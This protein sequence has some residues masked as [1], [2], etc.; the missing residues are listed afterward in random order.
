MQFL[1]SIF[2]YI[3]FYLYLINLKPRLISKLFTLDMK[4]LT[5]IMLLSI[6]NAFDAKIYGQD[7][8]LQGQ[9]QDTNGSFLE[10]LSCKITGEGKFQQEI[11]TD[12]FG[13]FKFN[14]LS[15]GKIRLEV[16]NE[17]LVLKDTI[18]DLNNSVDLGLL[19]VNSY[20]NLDELTIS[21]V[22]NS[23]EKKIDRLIFHVD[24]L[25]QSQ[26][27]DVYDLLKITPRVQIINESISISGKGKV[28]FLVDN[29]Y[30]TLEGE[31][32][33]AYL[34]SLRSDNISKIEVITNPNAQYMA[35]GSGGL[36]H[37]I[38]KKAK[39]DQ[40][41]ASVS[42]FYKQ[43]SLPT[44]G[45]DAQINYRKNQVTIAANYSQLEGKNT[46]DKKNH[47]YYPNLTWFEQ[48]LREDKKEVT[49]GRVFI[50]YKISD[51]WTTGLEYKNNTNDQ[52]LDSQA[53]TRISNP[54]T[55]T[56][57]SSIY[58]PSKRSLD[59]KYQSLNYHLVYQIDTLKRKLSFDFDVFNFTSRSDRTLENT[60][61]NGG[62]ETNI[63]GYE[64]ALN[65][66]FQKINNNS[67]NLS[68]E[69]P[70]EKITLEYG[71]RYAISKTKSDFQYYDVTK[72]YVDYKEDLSNAFDFK[73]NTLSIYASLY[74]KLNEKW[75]FKIGG[76]MESTKTAGISIMEKEKF[77]KNYTKFFPTAYISYQ[78]NEDQV[79]NINYSKRIDRPDF[80]S[81]NP[82]RWGTSKYS[83]SEGN[84][85]LNPSFTHQVEMEHQL[86]GKFFN[87][88]YF[89]S[90][91]G[92][93]EVVTEIDPE[94][95]IQKSTPQN[96]IDNNSYGI[97][98]T[99]TSQIAALLNINFNHNLSYSATTSQ[100]ESTLPKLKGWNYYVNLSNDMMLY[101]KH[102]LNLNINYSIAPNGVNYLDAYTSFN[103]LNLALKAVFLKE[104]LQVSFIVNDLFASNKTYFTS[105]SN[106][107]KNVVY[108]YYDNRYFRLSVKYSI[109][110][111]IEKKKWTSKNSEE[112]NR[113]N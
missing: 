96:F 49:N 90:T 62:N 48:N 18:V 112:F 81:L 98:Q 23:I 46:A 108:N 51:K 97:N 26:G 24:Q 87:S 71:G 88:I 17:E 111:S 56:I 74:K 45:Q 102:E 15:S 77:E 79:F 41:N 70:F 57:D 21:K 65:S 78:Y 93:Y 95:K 75:E 29:Q 104:Q 13:V 61:Y 6:V 33:A 113:L 76:R 82:F 43:S 16:F 86:K 11:K 38:T 68:M 80:T 42:T 89:T 3:L 110:G 107:V 36:I 47:T 7:N 100:I 9:L 32:L 99:Y 10:T 58:T 69:H 67:F 4:L 8:V 72:P 84:P 1:T 92:L 22:K 31:E 91:K 35:E 83:Y 39:K 50:D 105:Y 19:T 64:A 60:Y 53:R 63:T 109:G 30:I 52:T 14:N 12:A 66:G 34:H 54:S 28:G 73:E 59:K 106:G 94:L 37:I 40:W 103:E 55:T 85:Y 27:G 5:F 20:K 2:R 44:F 25:A 101:K